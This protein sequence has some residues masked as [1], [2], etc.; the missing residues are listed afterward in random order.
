MSLSSSI[1]HNSSSPRAVSYLD[2]PS[3][4]TVASQG[5][6]ADDEEEDDDDCD[7]DGEDSSGDE[8]GTESD[9]AFELIADN[10]WGELVNRKKRKKRGG[11]SDSETSGDQICD[12]PE[13]MPARCGDNPT[14]NQYSNRHVM[15][16]ECPNDCKDLKNNPPR[17]CN[18]RDLRDVHKWAKVDVVDHPDGDKMVVAKEVIPRGKIIGSYHGEVIDATEKKKR[19]RKGAN[20]CYIMQLHSAT[21]HG[22]PF[23]VDARKKGGT[24]RFVNHSCDPN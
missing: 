16:E 24:M 3:Q 13:D 17:H 18:N 6:A 11:S 10:D 21:N 23:F 15:K 8:S 14:G 22:G 7:G 9:K 20:G 5:C 1:P 12:C 19:L 4:G 2:R